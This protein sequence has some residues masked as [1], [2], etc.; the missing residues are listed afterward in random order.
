MTTAHRHKPA[1]QIKGVAGTYVPMKRD[2]FWTADRKRGPRV[3]ADLIPLLG[4]TIT[5]WEKL[6]KPWEEALAIVEQAAE[7]KGA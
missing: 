3:Y 6:G 7:K 2:E 1:P 5:E 4:M